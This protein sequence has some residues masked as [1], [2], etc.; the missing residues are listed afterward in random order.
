MKYQEI[1]MQAGLSDAQATLYEALLQVKESKAGKLAKK[2]PLKRGLVY[3]ALDDLVELGLA[4]KIENEGE[5]MRF[6]AKHPSFLRSFVEERARAARETE[7][8]LQN[9]LPAIVSEYNIV[10]GKPGV[11]IYEGEGGIERMMADTIT[12]RTDIYSYVDPE[13]VDKYFNRINKKYLKER[14]EQFIVKHL[15]VVK[16]PYIVGRYTKEKYPLTEV[17]SIEKAPDPFQVALQIYDGK[18]SY[19]TLLPDRII[20]VMIEDPNIYALQKFLF[21]RLYAASEILLAA[22]TLGS[23]ADSV[24]LAED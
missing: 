24:L 9:T 19:L 13:A 20:G 16:S 7:V 22:P 4:E 11:S 10:Q 2:Y 5:V 18:V 14:K 21:E 23:S 1:L 15:L 6:R 8:A 17:R 3:K 12:S